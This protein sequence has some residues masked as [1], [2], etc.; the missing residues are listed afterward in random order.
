MAQTL[1]KK[2]KKIFKNGSCSV[3]DMCIIISNY[4][5]DF[6]QEKMS[7]NEMENLLNGKILTKRDLLQDFTLAQIYYSQRFGMAIGKPESEKP[8]IAKDGALFISDDGR[9]EK[10][11]AFVDT[12]NEITEPILLNYITYAEDISSE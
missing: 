8:K 9:L 4:L 7:P 10:Y 1:R 5:D 11:D 6:W 12:W 2:F 3:R